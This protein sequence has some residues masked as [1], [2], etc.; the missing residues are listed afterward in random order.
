MASIARPRFDLEVML[1]NSNS[2][3]DDCRKLIYDL[4]PSY[5]TNRSNLLSNLPVAAFNYRLTVE[6]VVA[7]IKLLDLAGKGEEGFVTAC[8]TSLLGWCCLWWA[9][10]CY[11]IARWPWRDLDSCPLSSLMIDFGGKLYL[12]L[13]QPQL[14]FRVQSSHGVSDLDAILLLAELEAG[15]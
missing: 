2:A 13:M 14:P 11:R 5:L 4:D 6:D 7:V 10:P 3:Q 15:G 1:C 8:W 9:M 12:R